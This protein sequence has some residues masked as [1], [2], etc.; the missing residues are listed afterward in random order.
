[1]YNTF[2]FPISRLYQLPTSTQY[3]IKAFVSMLAPRNHAFVHC[4]GF[5]EFDMAIEGFCS[6]LVPSLSRGPRPPN[7]GGH[8]QSP[9]A[10]DG[11]SNFFN[12][13]AGFTLAMCA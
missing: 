8:Q 6:L 2:F 12:P 5:V 11:Q 3:R 10:A 13:I 7:G 4:P 9:V 1:M